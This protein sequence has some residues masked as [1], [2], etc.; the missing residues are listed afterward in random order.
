SRAEAERLAGFPLRLPATAGTPDELRVRTHL[1]T[2]VVSAVYIPSAALPDPGGS[3]VGMLLTEFRARVERELFAKVLGPSTTLEEVSVDGVTGY[4]LAGSPH[5]VVV[6][7]VHGD[8]SRDTLRLAENTLLWQKGD[9]TYRI[10]SAL[11]RDEVLRIA[12]SLR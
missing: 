11:P 2:E 4:W 9:V 10:E 8:V 7:D 12:A 3:G 5:E 1:S 6:K